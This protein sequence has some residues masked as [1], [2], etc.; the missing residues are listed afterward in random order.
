MPRLFL[1]Y[2]RADTRDPDYLGPLVRQLHAAGATV[3]V[4][5]EDIAAGFDWRVALYREIA[6]ADAVIVAASD[7]WCTRQACRRE[8]AFGRRW[9]V[10][11]VPVH[12]RALPRGTPILNQ[13]HVTRL[14]GG[15]LVVNDQVPPTEVYTEAATSILRAVVRRDVQVHPLDRAFAF[16]ERLGTKEFAEVRGRLQRAGAAEAHPGGFENWDDAYDAIFAL[17][18][19]PGGLEKLDGVEQAMVK[20]PRPCSVRVVLRVDGDRPALGAIHRFDG[21]G[22][23]ELAPPAAL[24]RKLDRLSVEQAV[25]H[26]ADAV[27]D[28]ADGGESILQI[29]TND[30]RASTARA[31]KNGRVCDRFR[32]VTFWPARAASLAPGR[33]PAGDLGRWD[34]NGHPCRTLKIQ[35]HVDLEDMDGAYASVVLQPLHDQASQ[36]HDTQY[37]TWLHHEETAP[38]WEAGQCLPF[39]TLLGRVMACVRDGAD[40]ALLWTDARYHILPAESPGT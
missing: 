32:G 4:D 34:A 24:L 36:R 9:S 5:T 8:E 40:A 29:A 10:P 11:I 14:G 21:A 16:M 15:P 19:C 31:D 35:D 38:A 26:T 18:D 22:W 1:S 30:V 28:A 2:A 27:S 17:A 13:Q 3:F 6:Y 23:T 25:A 39:D 37:L 20:P 7:W 12:L 33:E